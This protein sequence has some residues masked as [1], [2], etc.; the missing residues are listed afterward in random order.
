MSGPFIGKVQQ[1]ITS[2]AP[3][4]L[5]NQNLG[6]FLESVGIVQDLADETLAQGFRMGQPFRGDS[7]AQ[8]ALSRD[9]GILLYPTE[10]D[11]SRRER[12]AA[13]WQLHRGFGTHQGQLV[14]LQPYF[15]PAAPVMRIVHQ[16][17]AGGRATWHTL[18]AD[19]VYTIHKSEPSNWDYD[20]AVAEFSRA[21][22][23]IYKPAI[24][25][26]PVAYDDGHDWDGGELWDGEPT[27]DQIADIV[28]SLREAGGAHYALWAVIMTA[29]P[30][31]FDPTAI[32]VLDPDG[33]TSLPVGNWASC[34]DPTSGAPSRPPYASFIFEASP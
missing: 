29:D 28:G 10:P 11:A 3:W 2:V 9:R 19:G 17:G 8:P 34:I 13:W 30:A 31:S 21:F 32:A 16:D 25:A 26:D 27:T 24:Y 5:R 4:F 7:S 20:G 18:D 33:W 22:V 15:S 12:L 6:A 14:N 23:I 1:F